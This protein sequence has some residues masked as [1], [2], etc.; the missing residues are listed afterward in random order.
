LLDA[1]IGEAEARGFRQMIA[2]I[3]DSGHDRSIRLH[4]GAGFAMVGTLRNVGFKHGRWLDVVFM[5]RILGD[6]AETPPQR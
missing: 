5:Q 6:G 1:L 4:E 2:I 3:G